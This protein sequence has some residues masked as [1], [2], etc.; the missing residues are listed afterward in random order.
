[1]RESIEQKKIIESDEELSDDGEFFLRD[2][3]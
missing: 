2:R 1:M 3:S